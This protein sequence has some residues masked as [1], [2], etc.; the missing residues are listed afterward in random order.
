MKDLTILPIPDRLIEF[1]VSSG[2]IS[3]SLYMEYLISS[4]SKEELLSKIRR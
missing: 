2:K 4:M 3:L 1:A